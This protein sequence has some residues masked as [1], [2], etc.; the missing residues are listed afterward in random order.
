[1]HDVILAL[2]LGE[3]VDGDVVLFGKI[4]HVAA[5]TSLV[6]TASLVEAKRWPL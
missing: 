2:A 3:A 4:E 1:M 6:S 5:G